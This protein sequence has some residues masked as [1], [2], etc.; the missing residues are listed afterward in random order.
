MAIKLGH[1]ALAE[2]H[3]L[4]VALALRVEIGAALAAAHGK[5]GQ[6]IL[7]GLL[8]AEELEDRFVDRGVEADPALIGPDRIVVLDPVAALDADMIIVVL[9]DDAE[10]DHPVRL[11][12]APQ[13]LPAVIFLLVLDELE[14]VLCDLGHGLDEFGLAGIAPLHPRDEA[15]QIDMV[16]D[17]HSTPPLLCAGPMSRPESGGRA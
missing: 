13:D 6:G 12:D 3:H 5:A 8:E 4:M 7:E 1:E 15:V 16:L 17:R 11:G 14:N 10:A 2:A 9:P